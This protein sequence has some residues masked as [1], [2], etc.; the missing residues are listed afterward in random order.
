MYLKDIDC[1]QLWQDKL[2]EILPGGLYYLNESTGGV[3]GFGAVDEND[4][5][6]PGMRKGRGIAKAGD[7][8]SSLPKEMR[9]ENLMCYIG[10]E[11]TYTPAH[12]EMCASLGQNI[13]VE[14][15]NGLVE[16]GKSTRPGSSI[17]FM[18]ETKEREV[19]SEYW[20]SRLGHDIEI[21]N[22]FAQVNAWKNAPFKV[23]V[24]EQKPGDFILIPPLAPHQ[25]WNRGTRTVKVAWNRTTVETLE[26]AIHEALPRARMVCRD[27]Q[28]KN[29]AIIY[30]TMQKYS[31][32]LR[33]AEKAKQK[34][35]QGKGKAGNDAK[36]RQLEKDFR[37]LQFLFTEMLV[38]ESFL[39]DKL[40]KKV[41]LIPYDSNITCSYCRCNIFNR[42]LTCPTCVETLAKGDEDTYDV[43]MDCYAMGRSCGCISK[44]RWAEQWSWGELTQKHE[45]WR[46]Q[47]LQYE[48]KVT[49]KSPQSLRT[50]LDR[51]GDKRTLAQVCQ[52][53]LAR[54]PFRD[55]R[56]PPS[57][58]RGD[59]REEVEV[60]L[61]D[62]TVKIK[63]KVKRTD[64]FLREHGRCHTDFHWEPKWK[65]AA[66][67][68]C[69]KRYCYGTLYRRFDMMPQN[70]LADPN[71]T[72]PSCKQ[73]CSCRS[74]RA[75]A[76]YKYK[77]YTPSGTMLGHNTKAVA[78]P[79]SV[80]SLVDFSVS[81]IGWIQKADDDHGDQSRRLD[82]R[83]KEAEAAKAS[84]PQ[85][86]EHYVGEDEEMADGVED[87]ILRLAEQEGIPIDPALGADAVEPESPVDDEDDFEE[88][89]ETA[90]RAGEATPENAPPPQYALP[91]GG[92]IRDA[93]HAYDQTEAITYD[94]P[95]PEAARHVPIVVEEE[96]PALPPGYA[97]AG[98][99][100]GGDIEMVERKRK[101]VKL[102][103]GDRSYG[104]KK[105]NTDKKKQQQRKSLIV[106]LPMPIEKLNEMEKMAHMARQALKGVE[107]PAPVISSDLQALNAAE[108]NPQTVQKKVRRG[109]EHVEIEHDDEFM[110][111]RYR[112][113]RRRAQEGV[114]LPPPDAD[115]TRRQTR[116][117]QTHYEEPSEDEFN[118]IVEPKDRRK[119]TLKPVTSNVVRLD[120]V[121]SN[122]DSTDASENESADA[123][124]SAS[125]PLM[126]PGQGGAKAA[127]RAAT[128]ARKL[129]VTQT[130]IRPFS[131]DSAAEQGEV[132]SLVALSTAPAKK[133]NG[134]NSSSAGPAQISTKSMAEAQANRRAKLALI[135]SIG[136]DGDDVDAAW[137]E[138][139]VL[140]Q[141]IS[142]DKAAT[143]AQKV[144]PEKSSAVS[145]TSAPTH[146][147]R[148]APTP[149]PS[150]T[151]PS[152]ASTVKAS[153]ADWLDS[154][155][156]DEEIPARRAARGSSTINGG[157]A[158]ASRGLPLKRGRGRSLK[159][160]RCPKSRLPE[161]DT[162][163]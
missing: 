143:P 29:K 42:F 73:I 47:I 80:E 137:S 2:S 22:H 33:Q 34:S 62:G 19:V 154:D 157:A 86:G 59:D 98:L 51:L 131:R 129:T 77:P 151:K 127:P 101:R 10:H 20:L 8:M 135:E 113:R 115:I 38:S 15:S 140:D 149:A 65:Q 9:A 119:A 161:R 94:Y 78:D 142:N 45:Q 139:D 116:M 3:G 4:P 67:T 159:Y 31:K 120:D 91:A 106:K 108:G 70:I 132:S 93:E 84:E 126:E 52:L 156:S 75:K 148:S 26:M 68:K 74:C 12:R 153:A 16:D 122:S 85:L 60:T 110:P 1:P 125:S 105:P 35:I 25:V 28:Y 124:S 133:I 123:R 41:E 96:Q 138:D 147:S 146:D 144:P 56:R 11:G 112:D 69:D 99:E 54:R 82:K 90:R 7:L 97:P 63:K 13:M 58:I 160:S 100:E 163:P 37:R 117:H 145:A 134:A 44:L 50:E 36:V 30:Y 103:D 152:I 102:D 14:A 95:D 71:W 136:N 109:L 46:H 49:E 162:G 27:E 92:V 72:C 83:R 57:P 66:C 64:K 150:T 76:G 155:D 21:E 48:G 79:R 114:S 61:P 121:E 17:W 111:G 39:P 6:R 118:E 87:G 128:K 53:E 32:L 23:Y 89:P 88:N 104:Y 107:V 18:T 158:S 24:V 81:N 40:E 43:C 141:P 55:I 130:T 5:I